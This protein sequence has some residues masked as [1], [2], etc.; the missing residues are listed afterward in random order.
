MKRTG[1]ICEFNPF[2]R[3]HA[4]L[5][6]TVREM[7]GGQVVC[8]MS[9]SF[10]Q[11]GEP[12]IM[13]ASWRAAAAVE[14]GADA[15]FELPFPWSASSAEFFAGAGI[16]MLRDLGCDSFAFGSE[17]ADLEYLSEQAAKPPESGNRARKR[18]RRG[19]T[20]AGFGRLAQ[21]A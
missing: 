8:V 10:V 19:G 13:P 9:G 15:V 14:A 20:L 12:A 6:R 4:K 1:I 5:I 21:R 3:G 17:S 18:S 16:K 7:T 11:R 2:H